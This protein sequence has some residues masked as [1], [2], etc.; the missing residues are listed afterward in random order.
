MQ[1]NATRQFFRNARNLPRNLRES[2]VRHGRPTSDRARTQTVVQNFFLHLHPARTH[3]HTL[4]WSTTMCLGII[5]TVLFLILT[6][7]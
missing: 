4:K 3:K 6:V 1:Y 5:T 7:T 2:M